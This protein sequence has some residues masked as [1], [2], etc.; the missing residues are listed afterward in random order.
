[1]SG[2]ARNAEATRRLI[3][4]QVI[5]LRAAKPPAPWKEIETLFGRDRMTLWR[6]AQLAA[7]ANGSGEDVTYVTSVT[8]S[9]S[10][11]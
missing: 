5:A 3:G 1:M 4:A 9:P 11:D 2:F 8:S 6:Y 7:E 10:T